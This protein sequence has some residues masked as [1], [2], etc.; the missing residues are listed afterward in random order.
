MKCKACDGKG[1]EIII[2]ETPSGRYLGYRK[3]VCKTCHGTGRVKDMTKSCF[4]CANKEEIYDN[5][6]ENIVVCEINRYR[7]NIY[8]G[9]AKAVAERCIAY[10][11]EPMT[12]EEQLEQANTEEKALFLAR[13]Y[14]HSRKINLPELLFRNVGTREVTD[15]AEY[16]GKW[17]KEIHNG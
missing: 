9:E 15:V 11:E 4:N 7:E 8:P 5:G 14:G 1:E 13:V 16:I 10:K 6:E 2:K 17:L 12:N 3:E